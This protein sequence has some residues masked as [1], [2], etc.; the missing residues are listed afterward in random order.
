MLSN[1]SPL[2]KE[3]ASCQFS[4]IRITFGFTSFIA[5]LKERQKSC[6]TSSETSSLQPSIWYFLIHIV[7]ILIR[8]SWTSLQEVF[9]FAIP[10]TCAN[11]SYSLYS[12]SLNMNQSLYFDL[13]LLSWASLKNK[14]SLLAWLKTASKTIFIFLEC[15]SLTNSSK[16]W[17]VPNW[18][19]TIS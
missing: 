8:Y 19:S 11:F 16:S 18:L 4:P 17:F 5:F 3:W 12:L 15:I 14:I 9:H 13:S 7:P 10:L 1:W 2:R 6:E